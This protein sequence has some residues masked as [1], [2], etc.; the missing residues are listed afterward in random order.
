MGAKQV[1]QKLFFHFLL[2]LYVQEKLI[3]YAVYL[4]VRLDPSPAQAET[5]VHFMWGNEASRP[6]FMTQKTFPDT[7]DIPA[8]FFGLKVVKTGVSPGISGGKS[9]QKSS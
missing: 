4:A 2:F 6:D 1:P 5:P 3:F 9:H 8:P 7:R